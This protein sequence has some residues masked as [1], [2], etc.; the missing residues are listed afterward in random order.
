MLSHGSGAALPSV[1]RATAL[2]R[3]V[4]AQHLA[5]LGLL[6]VPIDERVLERSAVRED[7]SHRLLFGSEA[8]VSFELEGLASVAWVARRAQF[9]CLTCSGIA[10]MRA[11]VALLI[12]AS[13]RGA[14]G[15]AAP[16]KKLPTRRVDIA[17]T[18]CRAPLFRYA[19][20]NGAG[21]KLVKIYDERIVK[22]YTE[23]QQHCPQCG[24]QFA[25]EALVH[26]RLAYKVI[27]GK[28]SMK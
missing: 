28:V 19:K 3:L 4:Q 7:E 21:S 10:F 13:L 9:C 2:D 5:A 14:R 12:A 25:R 24:E 22:D 6:P 27:N 18:G 15:L 8:A 26:G 23:D 16:R 20:G 11:R 17:C 1:A